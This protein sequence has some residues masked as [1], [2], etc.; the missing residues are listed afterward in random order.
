MN[1]HLKP[2]YVDPNLFRAIVTS[3]QLIAQVFKV[4]WLGEQMDNLELKRKND[5]FSEY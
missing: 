3:Q 2:K 4:E 1:L 5:L